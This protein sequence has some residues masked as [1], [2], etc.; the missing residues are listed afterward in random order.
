LVSSEEEAVMRTWNRIG[1]A[2]AIG[3]PSP[4]DVSMAEHIPDSQLQVFENRGAITGFFKDKAGLETV[5]KWTV[6][7]Q[8]PAIALTAN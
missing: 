5:A 2:S 6:G 7:E 1:I 8:Q 4:K 3:A